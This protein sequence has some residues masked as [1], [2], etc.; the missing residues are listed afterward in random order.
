MVPRTDE[1]DA[2]RGFVGH[3]SRWHR[4]GGRLT[5]EMTEEIVIRAVAGRQLGMEMDL[6]VGIA[7]LSVDGDVSVK[8][9]SRF[10]HR[11][12]SPPLVFRV[13]ARL[14]GG[15]PVQPSESKEFNVERLSDLLRT[16][17]N[18]PRAAIV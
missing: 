3:Y 6:A 7:I 14:T 17:P 10:L 12:F 11:Q 15:K 9:V 16:W 1:S 18:L 5:E 2:C 13:I 4:S 8:R